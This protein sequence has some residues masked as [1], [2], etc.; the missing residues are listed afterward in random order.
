MT[1]NYIF[2]TLLFYYNLNKCGPTFVAV[3][4]LTVE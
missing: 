3:N 2:Q 1:F 4:T